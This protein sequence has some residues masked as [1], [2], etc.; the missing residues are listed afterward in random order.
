MQAT[1]D[2]YSAWAGRIAQAGKLRAGEKLRDTGW[3][4]L[5]ANGVMDGPYSESKE[6]I[7]GFYMIE[8]RDYD[9]A[10]ALCR[11]HPHLAFGSVEIRETE[12]I[13]GT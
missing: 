4:V 9:E 10:V 3:R 12:P 2:Q 5:T 11:D 13:R 8:A 1:I 7:G 6:F